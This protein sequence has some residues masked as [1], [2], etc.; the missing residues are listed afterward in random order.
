MSD[1]AA[2]RLRNIVSENDDEHSF[3]PRRPRTLSEVLAASGCHFFLEAMRKANKLKGA[4]SITILAP[5][6]N[7]FHAG[8]QGGF[9]GYH[10]H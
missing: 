6:D 7:A 5:N 4:N 1:S 8:M 2:H 3:D 9:L 10:I